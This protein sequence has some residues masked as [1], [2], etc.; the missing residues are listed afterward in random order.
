[1]RIR[2]PEAEDRGEWDRLFAAYAAFYG[3]AQTPAMRDR[4]WGWILDPAHEVEARV[5]EG[6]GGLV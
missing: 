4:V 5:A 6:A 1:M 2:R 3:V